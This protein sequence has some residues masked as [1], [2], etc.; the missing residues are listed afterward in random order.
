M[1]CAY[2]F[3]YEWL[4]KVKYDCPLIIDYLL[5]SPGDLFR[6]KD[7]E[8]LSYQGQI[9]GQVER[10]IVST[11]N[12][13]RSIHIKAAFFIVLALFCQPCLLLFFWDT[14]SV[15]TGCP[16]IDCILT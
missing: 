11:K 4:V 9:R 1:T 3:L 15:S 16:E 14:K 13:H 5:Y 2:V 6:G 12:P 10:L 8:L 7:T